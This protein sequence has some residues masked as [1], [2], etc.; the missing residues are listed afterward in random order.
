MTFPTM[1]GYHAG[2]FDRLD[3][4]RLS[5]VRHPGKGRKALIERAKTIA[6]Q[7]PFCP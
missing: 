5:R 7:C 3:T 6:R 4:E 2:I 1:C